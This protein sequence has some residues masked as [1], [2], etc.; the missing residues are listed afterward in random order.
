MSNDTETFADRAI[1][2][3]ARY[4]E[5]VLGVRAP[6]MFR[7]RGGLVE[8]DHIL[9]RASADLNLLPLVRPYLDEL[10]DASGKKLKRHRYFHHI[11]SSQALAINLF[12]P[13]LRDEG[14]LELLSTALE[15]NRKIARAGF[16]YVPDEQEGT[17]VDF[18]AEDERGSSI[19]VEVKFT[20]AGFGKAKDDEAHR[21]KFERIYR[22][23]LSGVA[24]LGEDERIQFFSAYQF[25]RNAIFASGQI[26]PGTSVWFLVPRGNVPVRKAAKEA[27]SRLRDEIAPHVKVVELEPF[28][29]RVR[30]AVTADLELSRH[31]DEFR[32]KY[33]VPEQGS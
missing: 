2:H 8:K 12:Y 7:Y 1:H 10:R 28:V 15:L 14:R 24:R 32:R 3:L 26:A 27:M 25:F 29:E 9:P 6:G 19:L 17:N 21:E 31:F 20:E 23:R 11:N 4:K 33:F 18:F 16:E 5:D 13:F 22:D 30:D